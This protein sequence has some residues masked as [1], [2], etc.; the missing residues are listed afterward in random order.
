MEE[1]DRKWIDNKLEEF[2]ERVKSIEESI[3]LLIDI[4]VKKNPELI[5]EKILQLKI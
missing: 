2:S 5:K 3:N 4:L 1:Q